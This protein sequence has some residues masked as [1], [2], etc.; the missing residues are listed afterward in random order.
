[1]SSSDNDQAVFKDRKP[2]NQTEATNPQ[3]GFYYT[4]TQGQS[5][6]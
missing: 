2:V 4:D 1:M 6:C 5:I 3:T